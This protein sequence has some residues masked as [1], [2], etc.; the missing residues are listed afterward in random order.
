MPDTALHC[1]DC[2]HYYI[3]HDLSFPYGCRAM[4][5]KSRRQPI[6]DVLEVTGAPCLTFTPRPHRPT[7]D[8]D[9]AKR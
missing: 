8:P 5:F 7:P 4:G 2:L 6:Q 9:S 1:R 3:T